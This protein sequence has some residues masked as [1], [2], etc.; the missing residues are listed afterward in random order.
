MRSTVHFVDRLEKQVPNASFFGSYLPA[1]GKNIWLSALLVLLGQLATAQVAPCFVTNTNAPSISVSGNNAGQS[2]KPTCTGQIT[3]VV[4]K[5][6]AAPT[7]A[8]SMKL[9][10][11]DGANCSGTLLSSQNFTASLSGAL[12]TITLAVPVSVIASNTYFLRLSTSAGTFRV[13]F[14]GTTDPYSG[15][16]L[17]WGSCTTISNSPYGTASDMYFRVNIGAS[18][19]VAP[20]M[21]VTGAGISVMDGDITPSVTDNTDYGTGIFGEIYDRTFTIHNNG[22]APLNLTGTPR[23]QLGGTHPGDFTVLTQPA[24]MIS[25]GGNSTFTVRFSPIATGLR[26]ATLTILNND[27]SEDPYNF[28]IQG[29]FN[30]PE[31]VGTITDNVLVCP[32]ASVGILPIDVYSSQPWPP[33]TVTLSDNTAFTT[34]GSGPSALPVTIAPNMRN[35]TIASIRDRFGCVGTTTGNAD[36]VERDIEVPTIICPIAV[37]TNAAT[38]QCYATPN[39]GTATGTDNCTAPVITNDAPTTFPV[40]ITAVTWTATDPST[41]AATCTQLVTVYDVTAPSITCPADQT[42]ETDEDCEIVVP[43]YRSLATAADE[44]VTSIEQCAEYIDLD[45]RSAIPVCLEPGDNLLGVGEWAVTLTVSDPS[46]NTATCAFLLTVEDNSTPSITCPAIMTV[47]VNEYYPPSR[48]GSSDTGAAARSSAM[49][50]CYFSS[51]Y[52]Y[53]YGDAVLYPIVADNCIDGTELYYTMSGAAE[54]IEPMPGDYFMYESLPVGLTTVTWMVTDPGGNT[55]SCSFDVTVTDEIDPSIACAAVINRNA[56]NVYTVDGIEFDP[57]YDDNCGIA[58]LTYTLSGVTSGSGSNTLDGVMFQQGTTTIVW[59]VTDESGNSASSSSMVIIGDTQA[60]TITCPTSPMTVSTDMDECSWTEGVPLFPALAATAV[61][62]FDNCF[63]LVNYTLS[64]ATSASGIA[65]DLVGVSLNKGTTV[66]TFTVTDVHGNT[67]P[68]TTCSF[69]IVVNDT[70]APIIDCPDPSTVT[71][72]CELLITDPMNYDATVTD[73]CAASLSWS[74]IGATDGGGTTTLS[75]TTLSYGT[76]TI[77]WTANDGYSTTSCSFTVEVSGDAIAPTFAEYPSDLNRTVE[78]TDLEA[79]AAAQALFPTAS[80][81]CALAG[82]PTYNSSYMEGVC[83]NVGIY[84]NTWT[85]Q[86]LEGNIST[87]TQVITITDLT[88]PVWTTTPGALD[89]TVECDD[90]LGFGAA[91]LLV[92]TYSDCDMTAIPEKTEGVFVAGSCP[93]SGTYTHTFIVIDAC[94]DTSLIFTQTITVIDTK[95]PTWADAPGDLDMSISCS[96]AGAIADAQLLVPFPQDGCS[97]S[98]NITVQKYPGVFVPSSCP[99]AGTYTNTFVAT[100]EC[101]NASTV[102]TQVITIFDAEDPTWLTTAGSLDRTVACSDIAGLA[103]AQALRPTASDACDPS[104]TVVKTAGIL[105]G[106]TVCG[107]ITNTFMA[108]DDCGNNIASAFTQVITIVDAVLPTIACPA[109]TTVAVGTNCSVSVPSYAPTVLTDNCGTPAVAQ[110]PAA[111]TGLS[112]TGTTVITL[113]ATDACGNTSSCAFNLN[114]IDNTNPTISCPTANAIVLS[115]PTCSSTLPAYTPTSVNDNCTASP[116]VVQTPVAGTPLTST[117]T[118]MVTLSATDD[119]GRI[120]TCSIMV[121]VTTSATPTVICPANKTANLNASCQFILPN[122]T[123][124]A[125]VNYPCSGASTVTQ[126]PVAGTIITGQ[127]VRTIVLTAT[128]PDGKVATC[129]FTVTTVDNTPPTVICPSNRNLEMGTGCQ[130]SIPDYRPFANWLDNCT[131]AGS[132]LKQ[133]LAP[134]APGTVVSGL[135]PITITLRARD[136]AG[137]TSTCAFVV[138]RVDQLAPF[139]S[140]DPGNEGVV[141]RGNPASESEILGFELAPNPAIDQVNLSVYGLKGTALVSVIDQ[142]G[143][144]VWEQTIE[145]EQTNLQIDLGADRFDSGLYLVTVRSD[146]SMV[147]KRLILTK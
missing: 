72:I 93:N 95:A 45:A 83:P 90:I 147:T 129:S 62:P 19:N 36:V 2:F 146:G 39:I 101:N 58:T 139:C 38:N 35:F 11:Y 89:R 79:L 15:G 85:A 108:A 84:T 12:T 97:F 53:Y 29:R 130:A 103:A 102:Y 80:D 114:R 137:R 59:V 132:I 4:F 145:T 123:S 104:V 91:N 7:A 87:Y 25:A 96:D 136:A 66:A 144:T 118:T 121:R 142:L 41:N 16:R 37:T 86:D 98:E 40:G 5:F 30:C 46:G 100:D 51:Y 70:Q 1:F 24:A 88:P 43:D 26:R 60:P 64:G 76:T 9:D 106:G 138:T 50:S 134:Y 61:T 13:Y 143:R 92:P 126:S 44:C 73:N 78:C 18:A 67:G 56:C 112:G 119:A 68:M 65:T 141:E 116:T 34:V 54:A 20:E 110:L 22:T 10:I 99:N 107:T 117:G 125:V 94:L 47:G 48:S 14:N 69:S 81:N 111:G 124:E 27:A 3:S 28:D 63:Y 6:Q 71:G 135:G 133:Q 57:E 42:V 113:T 120:G 31:I 75:G 74:L 105:T 52:D 32:S 82:E 17:V 55:A 49:I 23:V 128:T 140:S 131:G 8:N 33:Y 127:T 21:D 109:N 122:Y 115:S 77:T